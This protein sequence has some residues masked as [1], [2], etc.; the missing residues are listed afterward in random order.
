M[1]SLHQLR[2]FL[3]AYER[4]S[5]TAAA[6]DLG[7]AQPSVSEQIRALER[8]LGTTPRPTRRNKVVPSDRSRLRICSET[9]GCAYPS[10]SAAAVREPCSYAARKQR[11]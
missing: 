4:G 1:L 5:I 9:D 8:T 7:Y 10:C 6:E 3:A 2:C 11:S